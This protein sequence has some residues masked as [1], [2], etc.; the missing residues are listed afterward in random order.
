MERTSAP[1]AAVAGRKQPRFVRRPEWSLHA[2]QRSRFTTRGQALRGEHGRAGA[3]CWLGKAFQAAGRNTLFALVLPFALSRSIRAQW[4][5]IR[6]TCPT[7]ENPHSRP[8][9]P[10]TSDWVIPLQ[11]RE[12]RAEPGRP[13]KGVSR[14]DEQD[15]CRIAG[16]GGVRGHERRALRLSL[17]QQQAIERIA[18]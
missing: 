3:M 1:A 4:V 12:R 10:A 16:E 6:C 9:L 7:I 5:A 11:T 18:V 2:C 17:R 13:G 15:I 8:S 14:S